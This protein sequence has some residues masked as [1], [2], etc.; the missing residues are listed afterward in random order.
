MLNEDLSSNFQINKYLSSYYYEEQG[1]ALRR[2]MVHKDE[3]IVFLL[4]EFKINKE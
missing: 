4:N 1:T 3:Y 2:Y